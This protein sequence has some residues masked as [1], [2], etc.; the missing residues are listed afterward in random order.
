MKWDLCEQAGHI[1]TD[2]LVFWIDVEP[3][4]IVHKFCG[5]LF[6]VRV[7][8]HKGNRILAISLARW[9]VG[10]P[11]AE[12]MDL[13]GTPSLWTLGSHTPVLILCIWR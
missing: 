13:I 12:T 4:N 9:Y 5:I 2:E 10:E 6:H 7:L 11:T 8:A 1:K 3:L